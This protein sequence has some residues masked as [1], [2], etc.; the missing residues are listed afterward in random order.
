MLYLFCWRWLGC[1]LALCRF[2]ESLGSSN[3]AVSMVTEGFPHYFLV[4][5]LQCAVTTH[6]YH[7]SLC[8][9]VCVSLPLHNDVFAFVCSTTVLH[10]YVVMLP[11]LVIPAEWLLHNSPQLLVRRPDAAQG[12]RLSQ[13]WTGPITGQTEGCSLQ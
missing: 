3:A 9:C 1:V 8:V 13:C 5:L 6:S 7:H 4:C 11:A 12:E 10:L 2:E